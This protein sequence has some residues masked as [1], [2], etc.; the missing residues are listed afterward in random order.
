MAG[1]G[2]GPTRILSDKHRPLPC[3]LMFFFVAEFFP[4]YHVFFGSL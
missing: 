4:P 3:R 1:A 2:E